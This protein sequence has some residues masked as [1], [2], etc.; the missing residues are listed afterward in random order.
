[1]RPAVF[2]WPAVDADG[3][4]LAQQLAGAGNLILNGVLV[5]PVQPGTNP[6]AKLPGIQRTI[7]LTSAG[8]LSAV[9]FT[10]TGSD[11]RGNAISEVIAGPNANTVI[12]TNQFTLVTGVAANAAVGA[13][14]TVGTGEAGSTNWFIC[15]Q[16][17]N[18]FNIGWSADISGTVDFDLVYTLGD[19]QVDSAPISFDIDNA[20]TADISGAFTTPCMAV[21][22]ITG[23]VNTGSYVLTL[24]Q[25]G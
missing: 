3:I 11:L 12:T 16:H 5:E 18:P 25:A 23:G 20:V 21:R 17:A 6:R 7:T 10:V 19:V 4:A 22:G 8:N 2:N 24:I 15:D 14:V 9:N 13:D 1:M